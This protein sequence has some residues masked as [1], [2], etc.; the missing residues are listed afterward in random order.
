MAEPEAPYQPQ[1]PAGLPRLQR[2]GFVA[3][4]GVLVLVAAYV[5]I[6]INQRQHSLTAV[7]RYNVTW[8]VSQGALEVAR[9]VVQ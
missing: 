2:F 1:P 6:L 4:I 8:L 5:S 3:I 9:L 7:S